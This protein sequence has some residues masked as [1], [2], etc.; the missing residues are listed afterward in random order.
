MSIAN[1]LHMPAT[2]H[3]WDASG[4][5]PDSGDETGSFATP[6]DADRFLVDVRQQQSTERR[7]GGVVVITVRTAFLPASIPT[8]TAHDELDVE[9][10]GR[11]AFEGEP[12]PVT[13][14]RTSERLH[15][16]GIVRSVK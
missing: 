2:L 15:W 14:P 5:D 4:R 6:T 3:R 11:L 8:L 1:R 7:N 9:G 12:V 13:N 16:E 10:I